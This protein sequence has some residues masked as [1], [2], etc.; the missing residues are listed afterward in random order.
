MNDV[1]LNYTIYLGKEKYKSPKEYSK[2]CFKIHKD[3]WLT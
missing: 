2:Y 1:L 3:Q